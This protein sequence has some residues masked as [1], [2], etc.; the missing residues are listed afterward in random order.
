[1]NL[2]KIFSLTRAK[3][4]TILFFSFRPCL[5]LMDGGKNREKDE[6]GNE[7]KQPGI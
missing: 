6:R 5:P 7:K 3:K 4:K 2:S 1:M